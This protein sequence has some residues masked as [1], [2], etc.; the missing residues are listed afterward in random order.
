MEVELIAEVQE[1]FSSQ[2]M[3]YWTDKLENEGVCLS[4]VLTVQESAK[5]SLFKAGLPSPFGSRDL[6][7]APTL[8]ADNDE[9]AP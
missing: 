1:I 5:H 2:S 4:P 8:G 6:G 3:K 9:L 7:T